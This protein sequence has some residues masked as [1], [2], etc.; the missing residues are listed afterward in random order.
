M[1]IFKVLT[2]YLQFKLSY[3]DD[4]NE[5]KVNFMIQSVLVEKNTNLN[6]LCVIEMFDVDLHQN[7]PIWQVFC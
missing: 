2:W 4:S 3:K 6:F 5:K 1:V 7:W